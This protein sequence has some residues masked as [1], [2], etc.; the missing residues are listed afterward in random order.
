MSSSPYS[1]YS[2]PQSPGSRNQE[3]GQER[4]Q[5]G[6]QDSRQTVGPAEETEEPHV[7]RQ[8]QSH[9]HVYADEGHELPN[10][11]G[12]RHVHHSQGKMPNPVLQFRF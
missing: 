12:R 10:E 9:L 4:Q 1:P 11:D 6:V 7:R 3:D 5:R 2:P 8:L